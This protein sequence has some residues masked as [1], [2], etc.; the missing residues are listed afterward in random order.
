MEIHRK[1]L[2][3]AVRVETVLNSNSKGILTYFVLTL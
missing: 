3:T 1:M 2:P